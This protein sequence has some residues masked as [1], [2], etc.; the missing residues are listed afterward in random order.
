MS[1]TRATTA[2][3][4]LGKEEKG[5]N[6]GKFLRFWT[7]MPGILTALA[8]V[9]SAAIPGYLAL[10]DDGGGGR[11][12]PPIPIMV[13]DLGSSRVQQVEARDS[14]LDDPVV[15]CGEGDAD[16]C[17]EV[18]EVLAD[19]CINGD[20]LACDVIYEV[21]EAD[22]ELEWFAAT[23]AYRFDSDLYANACEGRI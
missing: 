5:G 16:A 13:I 1:D 20:G 22:S 17:A 12:E 6:D 7:T 18:L 8:A 23:C 15:A 10:R 3:P 14:G 21:S 19:E 11:P 2:E 4:D 9:M